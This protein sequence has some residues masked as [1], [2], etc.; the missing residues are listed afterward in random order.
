MTGVGS[1]VHWIV[2]QVNEKRRDPIEWVAAFLERVEERLGSSGSSGGSFAFRLFGD[3][4]G[5]DVF[6]LLACGDALLFIE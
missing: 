2:A 1:E 3:F 6:Q 5:F 4:A